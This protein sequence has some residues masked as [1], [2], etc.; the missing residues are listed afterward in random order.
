MIFYFSKMTIASRLL[1]SIGH[2]K[3]TLSFFVHSKQPIQSTPQ[4]CPMLSRQKIPLNS[5]KNT[6]FTI[7]VFQHKLIQWSTFRMKM[8]KLKLALKVKNGFVCIPRLAPCKLDNRKSKNTK[9]VI[10]HQ[11]RKMDLWSTFPSLLTKKS[12]I[13]HPNLR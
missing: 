5:M 8:T 11:S 7:S 13:T 9:N 3:R 12:E 10:F 1:V 2:L 4:P 6:R